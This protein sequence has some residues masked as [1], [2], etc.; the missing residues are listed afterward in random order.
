MYK[1]TTLLEGL[2]FHLHRTLWSP[3]RWISVLLVQQW[4]PSTSLLVAVILVEVCAPKVSCWAGSPAISPVTYTCPGSA[5]Q[6]LRPTECPHNTESS[7][8]VVACRDCID[9]LLNNW[10]GLGWGRGY[11]LLIWEDRGQGVNH[12]D[13]SSSLCSQEVIVRLRS[14]W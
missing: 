4:G 6:P 5:V 13:L 11:K 2:H 3:E 10:P 9:T 8:A 12:F 1:C 7:L 14:N